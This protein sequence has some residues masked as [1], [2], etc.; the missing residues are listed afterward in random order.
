M[1]PFLSFSNSKIISERLFQNILHWTNAVNR[2]EA[3][4]FS[5]LSKNLKLFL[6]W[7]T[8]HGYKY[9]MHFSQIMFLSVSLSVTELKVLNA[10]LCGF[11]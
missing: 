1:S 4:F 9:N 2:V 5:V 8:S 3:G 7:K 11:L 6:L 10:L